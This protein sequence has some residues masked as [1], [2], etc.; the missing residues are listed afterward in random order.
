MDEILK[1]IG[2]AGLVPVAVIDDSALAPK[3]AKALMDGGLDI[4]EI[5]MR[6]EH[7]IA[8]IE[9]V[10]QEYPQMLV[11]A[12]TVLSVEKAEQALKAGA[13]FIVSPGFNAKLAEWCV[14]RGI[15]YTPGCVTPTEIESALEY[16]LN[17]LKFFP[18]GVYGGIEGCKALH[19]P[20]R[21]VSFI[22]TGGI[23]ANNLSE[24]ADKAY[25]HAIGGGWLC[26]PADINAR[27]FDA[28]TKT[29]KEAIDILLGFE[30]AHIGINT[31]DDSESLNTARAFCDCFGFALKL[32]GKSNFASGGIEV[33]K[34]AGPG[35]K[36]H[37]A[38]RTNS[39]RRAAHYLEKRGY[40]TEQ[41]IIK[42]SEGKPVAVY[43]S[44]SF[45]GF[46]VHLLQ[47]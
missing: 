9:S 42:N 6:T 21:T 25:I 1:R 5:T 40:S 30:F 7:G 2:N 8:S 16:G 22:P 33:V 15:A 10:K 20:Y 46:A 27:N 47:K 37:I 26:S 32:G 11:G 28:V 13:E 3:A 18:A 14:G 31:A 38:V 29:A 24:Y 41:D 39:L 45:A 23:G 17:V 4:M 19:G 43:L 34:G 44:S 36:G 12:G 35:A